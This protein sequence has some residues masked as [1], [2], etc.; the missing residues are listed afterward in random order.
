MHGAH[1][2]VHLGRVDLASL[3]KAQAQRAVEV[4]DSF[5]VRFRMTPNADF[6]DP[7]DDVGHHATT[8]TGGRACCG[9][10]GAPVR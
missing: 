5:T 6:F 8:S 4:I 9:T 1:R 3:E 7:V 2:A 10:A